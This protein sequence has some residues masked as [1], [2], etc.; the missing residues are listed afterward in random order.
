MF[1]EVFF[2]KLIHD[3]KPLESLEQP[4]D[5]VRLFLFVYLF[6]EAYVLELAYSHGKAADF[7]YK[8]NQERGVSGLSAQAWK[9]KV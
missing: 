7:A 2:Y 6:L 1:D 5:K 3:G 9:E 4:D 8:G